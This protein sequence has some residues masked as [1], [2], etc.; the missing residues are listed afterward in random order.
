MHK[1]QVRRACDKFLRLT[2]HLWANCFR[3]TSA[4]GQTYYEKKRADGM[5]HACAL[6][7]LGQRLLKILFKMISTKTPYDAEL[8]AKNQ[9]K[10]G[11]WVIALTTN[12]EVSA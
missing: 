4:W 6:R 7:C 5:S 9:K 8:H 2:V 11:S 1:V 10:H 12:N 3:K